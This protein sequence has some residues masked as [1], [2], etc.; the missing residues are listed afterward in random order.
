MSSTPKKPTAGLYEKGSMR[1]LGERIF[2]DRL[3]AA[4]VC[5]IIVFPSLEVAQYL[6]GHMKFGGS[7][8]DPDVATFLSS[9]SRGHILH[10]ILSWFLPLYLLPLVAETCIEDAKTGYRN[11]LFCKTGRGGYRRARL[12][13]GFLLPFTIICCGLLLNMIFVQFLALGDTYY[14]TEPDALP[15]VAL[16]TWSMAHPTVANLIFIMV[17]AFYA[18]LIGMLGVS[19]AMAVPN[20]KIVYLVTFACWFVPTILRESSLLLFQPF[21]EY[22]FGTLV[23]IFIYTTSF[24][25]LVVFGAY[26]WENR[27]DPI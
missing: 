25:L 13:W 9:S 22:D 26:V 21:T 3:K 19:L 1:S 2:K 24:Y 23:P 4:L 12:V 8:P 20:R 11:I 10:S 14:L 6:Y 5:A 18:G 17:F 16:F 15:R 27:N 7:F